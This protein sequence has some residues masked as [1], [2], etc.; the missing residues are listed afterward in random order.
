M[1]EHKRTIT[2]STEDFKAQANAICLRNGEK[3]LEE[4]FDE[5]K[6]ADALDNMIDHHDCEYGIT[7]NT[8]EFYLI[9]YCRSK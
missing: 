9:E 6:F 7:W 5:S 1:K 3:D 2:W 8:V 4:M